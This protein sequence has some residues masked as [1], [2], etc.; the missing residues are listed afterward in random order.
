MRKRELHNEGNRSTANLRLNRNKEF[1]SVEEEY[2]SSLDAPSKVYEEKGLYN[3]GV[4]DNDLMTMLM[5][6]DE[7]FQ[8]D[9]EEI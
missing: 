4:E 3:S 2:G 8:A 7:S 1:S 5:N 6:D 9:T